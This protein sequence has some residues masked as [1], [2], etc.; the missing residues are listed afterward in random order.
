MLRL[1]VE[2]EEAVGERQ[3][4]LVDVHRGRGEIPNPLLV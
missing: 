2:G 3:E 4:P 1:L